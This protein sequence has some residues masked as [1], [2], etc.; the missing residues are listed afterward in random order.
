[1]RHPG[2]GPGLTSR[3]LGQQGGDESVMLSEA[4]MPIHSH[5]ARG[6]GRPAIQ[7]D[8]ADRYPAATAGFTPYNSASNLVNMASQALPATGGGQ[9]HNNMQPFLAM[10]FIIALQ[11]IYPSRS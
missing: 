3:R 5:G 7:D 2:R 8:P 9:A 1:M 6:S 10:N 4:Q 11:G